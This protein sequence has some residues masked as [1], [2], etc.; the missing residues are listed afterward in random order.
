[1]IE[2][3]RLDLRLPA[4]FATRAARIAHLVAQALAESHVDGH[5][6][7]AALPLGPV[8]VDPR[9]PDRVVGAQ[10]ARHIATQLQQRAQA[11]SAA[12]HAAAARPGAP[13]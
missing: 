4:A 9:R 3:D 8:H 11:P 2:I 1:V 12:P 13:R 5:V 10:I 7:L 6:D